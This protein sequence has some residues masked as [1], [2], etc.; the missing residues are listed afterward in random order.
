ML[1]FSIL[2]NQLVTG[3]IPVSRIL[4]IALASI[5]YLCACMPALLHEWQTTACAAS[6]TTSRARFCFFG[7]LLSEYPNIR[8]SEWRRACN[9]AVTH[10]QVKLTRQTELDNEKVDK[11]TT[12]HQ[13]KKTPHHTKQNKTNL[14]TSQ[15]R[16]LAAD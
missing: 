11:Q 10:S 14:L 3:S 13:Y 12:D 1:C 4:F 16:W 2:G 9:V 8:I 15:S 7:L 6:L 5:T